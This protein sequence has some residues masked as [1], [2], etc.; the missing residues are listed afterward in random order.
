MAEFSDKGFYEGGVVLVM[1]RATEAELRPKIGA[2][3]GFVIEN[4]SPYA[5]TTSTPGWQHPRG[6]NKV[7]GIG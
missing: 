3:G 7:I 5:L 4:G 1:D 2:A 6:Y